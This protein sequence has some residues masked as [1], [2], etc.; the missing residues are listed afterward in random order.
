M[1]RFSGD[2]YASLRLGAGQKSDCVCTPLQLP[3]S[4]LTILHSVVD[5]NTLNPNPDLEFW[6]NLDLDPGPYPD[7][8]P[9]PGLC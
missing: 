9:D 7:P 8:D 5:P 2:V 4:Y 3:R 1:A 6:S